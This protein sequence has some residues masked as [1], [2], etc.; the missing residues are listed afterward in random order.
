MKRIDCYGWCKKR[1]ANKIMPLYGYC[2]SL[3]EEV[4]DKIVRI[5][6]VVNRIVNKNFKIIEESLRREARGK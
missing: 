5:E 2:I 3:S 6:I 1:V 4:F